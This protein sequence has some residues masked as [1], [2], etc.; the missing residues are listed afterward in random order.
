[1]PTDS[2]VCRLFYLAIGMMEYEKGGIAISKRRK[3]GL[4]KLTSEQAEQYRQMIWK[5]AQQ[6]VPGAPDAKLQEERL[7]VQYKSLLLADS[8]GK[9]VCASYSDQELLDILR[10]I[11]D[12]LGHAPTQEET[13]FLYRVYLKARF[14]N[15]PAVLHA[16]GMRQLPAADLEMPDWERIQKEEPEICAALEHVSACQKQIGYPP[17]KRDISQAKFLCAYFRTWENVIAAAAAFCA[18]KTE[19]EPAK[20]T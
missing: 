10:E 4:A 6:F 12:G 14:R 5:L 11:A 17:R 2:V 20:K 1:M 8:L 18:W 3:A 19:R 9:A 13:F 15:W 16:A 7:R